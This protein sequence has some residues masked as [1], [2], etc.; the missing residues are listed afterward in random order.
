MSR[1]YILDGIKAL[2]FTQ[3]LAGPAATRLLV[4]MG[5]EI[6]KIEE[7]T[8]GDN[9]RHFPYK[10]ED[11]RSAYYTQ[12]NRGKKPL[13]IDLESEKGK[14]IIRQMIPHFDVLVEIFRR[15]L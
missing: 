15:G 2:D 3:F 5:A 8:F 12:Q 13:G 7:V 11:G 6:V 14:A 1:S 9:S 4:E 10:A